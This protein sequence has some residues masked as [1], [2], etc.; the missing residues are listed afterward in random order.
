MTDC[1]PNVFVSERICGVRVCGVNLAKTK[2]SLSIVD[3]SMQGAKVSD[4]RD[5]APLR[6]QG[7]PVK[8]PTLPLHSING[9]APQKK[10]SP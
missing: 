3:L 9:S 2:G 1:E 10:L 6:E 7:A 5:D 4:C 8:D